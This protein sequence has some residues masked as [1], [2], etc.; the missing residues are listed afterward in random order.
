LKK[1]GFDKE[2]LIDF[3]INNIYTVEIDEKDNKKFL[4]LVSEYFNCQDKDFL[5]K[6]KKHNYN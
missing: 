1:Q 2:L 5:D 3:F 6:I 4:D